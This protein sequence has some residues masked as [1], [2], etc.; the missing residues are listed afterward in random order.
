MLDSITGSISLAASLDRETLNE[1]I[2]TVMVRDGGTPSKRNY[3]RVQIIVH[4]HNDHTPYFSD[5]ILEGKVFESAAVGSQVLRAYAVD[6]D[7]GENARVSYSLVSG[8]VGNV[9]KIDPELGIISIA[10]ELDLST[11]TGNF[12]IFSDLVK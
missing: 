5:K 1:H 4:D 2:L 7:K 8:N 6:H 11:V 3:A 10:R 9:F 12:D